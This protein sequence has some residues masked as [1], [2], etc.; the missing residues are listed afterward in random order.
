MMARAFKTREALTEVFCQGLAKPRTL[1]WIIDIER[2][3]ALEVGDRGFCE[4]PPRFENRPVY[5]GA[6][7]FQL[8]AT[9]GL[10]LGDAVRLVMVENKMRVDWILFIKEA[11]WN[12]WWD[13]AT[14]QEI[15][16]AL[17]DAEID[18]LTIQSILH[19]VKTYM[20]HNPLVR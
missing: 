11:R 13:F 14:L 19:R 16:D 17:E 7:L 3:Y 1:Y 8:K 20:Q 6:R 15:Q 9:H 4:V 2:W 12:K 18:D 10:P 5:S